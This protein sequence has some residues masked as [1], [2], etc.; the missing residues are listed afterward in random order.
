MKNLGQS[1]LMEHFLNEFH[2]TAL[3]GVI[4]RGNEA[5][6]DECAHDPTNFCPNTGPE[7]ISTA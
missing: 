7:G 4:C 5:S 1:V 6:I 3:S 2:F